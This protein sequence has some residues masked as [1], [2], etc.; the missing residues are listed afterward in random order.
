MDTTT[1]Y[2]N[3]HDDHHHQT[4]LYN[5]DR[6]LF[7]SVRIGVGRQSGEKCV[8]PISNSINFAHTHFFL[9]DQIET[10]GLAGGKR[11]TLKRSSNGALANFYKAQAT[12]NF[13]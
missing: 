1:H 5:D 3:S 9:H 2:T 10:E 6:L 12:H 4:C 11:P 13:A 7:V 8:R